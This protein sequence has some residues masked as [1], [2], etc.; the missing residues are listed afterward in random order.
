MVFISLNLSFDDIL[1][2]YL[3]EATA[4]LTIF[5][6]LSLFI[7][8]TTV[9]FLGASLADLVALDMTVVSLNIGS[10]LSLLVTMFF[11]NISSFEMS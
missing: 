9:N 7:F 10:A 8:S 11:L 6:A 3:L 4:A 5:L 1:V 2:V